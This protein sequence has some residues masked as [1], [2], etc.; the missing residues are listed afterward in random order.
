MGKTSNYFYGEINRLKGLKGEMSERGKTNILL[1][2]FGPVVIYLV[3]LG[4]LRLIV[5]AEAYPEVAGAVLLY[6]V[7]L[8]KE[9]VAPIAAGLVDAHASV[10][11]PLMILALAFDDII[12]TL[13]MLLN[14]D[15]IKF[16]PFVGKFFDNVEKN[17][18]KTVQERKWLG[19]FSTVGLALLVTFPMRGTG[20]I[21]GPIIG[22]MLGLSDRNI[23]ISIAT[24]GI[25][26]FSVLV[27]AFYFAMEPIQRFFGIT[28]TAAVSGIMFAAVVIIVG[29]FWFIQRNKNKRAQQ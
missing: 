5:G 20:G 28:S 6:L 22:K 9:M 4:V 12:C 25:A 10:S 11:M 1:R 29:I 16:I 17:S 18:K 24:G 13:W 19:K 27:P 15:V 2:I 3:F 8:G 14:W 7:A 26:G 23:F 21:T